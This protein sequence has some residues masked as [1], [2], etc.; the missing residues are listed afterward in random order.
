MKEISLG[1]LRPFV[2]FARLLDADIKKFPDLLCAGDCRLFYCTGGRGEIR[3]DGKSY[4]MQIGTLIYLAPGIPYSYFRDPEEPM[5]LLAFN[6]DLVWDRAELSVPFPPV[7]AENFSP[8]EIVA[9]VS[10]RE[11]PTLAGVL[12]LRGCRH[13]YGKLSEI[14]GEFTAAKVHFE[15]RCSGLMLAVLMHLLTGDGDVSGRKQ[16]GIVDAVIDYIGS[17]YTHEI[18]NSQ[19]GERFG[20]HPNYLN[21]LFLR[22]TGKPLHRYLQETRVMKAI[23]LL[24]ET[25]LPVMEV[26]NT[27]GFRDVPHFSR[28]FKEKTGY[29]PSD[30]R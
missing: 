24:Q 30:F 7:K 27:V 29:S 28:Y 17:N 5:K 2:R 4:E 10:V 18:T 20:Y 26:A 11:A 14:H 15:Q 16:A 13:L 21:Q 3:A 22:Y 1:Q 9:G 6:F 12:M 19:L 8:E 23:A 25:E